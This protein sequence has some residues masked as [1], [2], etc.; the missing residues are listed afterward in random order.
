MDL[1]PAASI[2]SHSSSSINVFFLTIISPL[3]GFFISSAAVLPKNSF[4]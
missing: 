2:F 4:W 1:T 3:I